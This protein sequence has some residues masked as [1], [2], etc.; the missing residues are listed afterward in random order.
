MMA[1]AP[2][3]HTA[4]AVSTVMETMKIVKLLADENFI[5]VK[6][7]SLNRILSTLH[8][9]LLYWINILVIFLQ[10][11]LILSFFLEDAFTKT[12]SHKPVHE[13]SLCIKLVKS[14]REV[15]IHVRNG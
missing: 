5:T 15:N 2:L 14:F 3:R 7:Q 4:M 8:I 9:I 10:S 1:V 13:G 12:L 11:G 6:E